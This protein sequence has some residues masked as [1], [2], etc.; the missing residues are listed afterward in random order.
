MTWLGPGAYNEQR[1]AVRCLNGARLVTTDATYP[2]DSI[3]APAI[4]QELVA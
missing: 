3:V 4:S 2:I 1:L